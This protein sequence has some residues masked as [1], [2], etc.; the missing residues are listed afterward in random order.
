MTLPSD[1][2][3]LVNRSEEDKENVPLKRKA[4]KPCSKKRLLSGLDGSDASYFSTPAQTSKVVHPE[5]TPFSARQAL[6]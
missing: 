6:R 4:K 2:N 1:G 3:A 5:R